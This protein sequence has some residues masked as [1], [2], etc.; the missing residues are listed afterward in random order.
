MSYKGV[1]RKRLKYVLTFGIDP[2]DIQ[3]FLKVSQK[4]LIQAGEKLQNLPKKRSDQI[5][6]ILRFGDKANLV[7]ERWLREH[8]PKQELIPAA[9]IVS[10]FREVEED[11]RQLSDEDQRS[12]SRSI[13]LHLLQP[14]VSDELLAFM[15]TPVRHDEGDAHTLSD[16]SS[17]GNTALRHSQGPDSPSDEDLSAISAAIISSGI[18]AR[19]AIHGD[20]D[21]QKFALALCFARELD[22]DSLA[23]IEATLPEGSMYRSAVDRIVSTLKAKTHRGVVSLPIRNMVSPREVKLDDIETIAICTNAAPQGTSVFFEPLYLLDKDGLIKCSDAT[24]SEIFPDTGQIMAFT[25]ALTRVPDVG[26]VGAWSVEHHDTDR[27]IK[28]HVRAAATPVFEVVNIDAIS[29]DYGAVRAQLQSVKVAGLGRAVFQTIDKLLFRPRRDLGDIVRDGIKEPFDAWLG[30]RG[31][32]TRGRTF[33]LVSLGEQAFAYDCAPIDAMIQRV[34]SLGSKLESSP[35]LTKAEVRSLADAIGQVNANIDPA[36][37]NDVRQHL[38]QYLQTTAGVDEVVKLIMMHPRVQRAIQEAKEDAALL[39]K[40]ARD[41]LKTDIKRLQEERAALEK[42]IE[43]KQAEQQQLPAKVARAVRKA[44]GKAKSD[45]VETLG[46]IAVL[47][48]LLHLDRALGQNTIG[49]TLTGGPEIVWAEV[50]CERVSVEDVLVRHGLSTPY[51]VAIDRTLRVA[52]KAGLIVL[53]TGVASDSVADEIA[54]A[55]TP[56]VAMSGTIAIGLLGAEHLRDQVQQLGTALD[57]LVLK[58]ANHSDI[59]SYGSELLDYVVKRVVDKDVELPLVILTVSTGPSALPISVRLRKLAI[60]IDLDANTITETTNASGNL[61]DIIEEEE[62]DSGH[63]IWP[64]L[65]KRLNGAFESSAGD[66]TAEVAELLR[67]GFIK[68]ALQI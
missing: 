42:A 8:L 30:L 41:D 21:L 23:E 52:S 13:V 46:T 45:G 28:V 17:D 61:R 57:G 65:R 54:R 29:D 56:K 7:L 24:Y 67:T 60:Q 26:S 39:A 64:P 50:K 40:S 25:N 15:K 32:E 10:I 53:F 9:D 2:K 43:Q 14:D 18:E 62:R 51:A 34:V 36:R 44:F 16:S 35:K 49:L 6:A 11:K 20:S 5:T 66:Q 48:H 22:W 37:L 38:D 47:E 4:R 27:P 68:P 33:V 55:M 59:D 63:I 19:L 1:D 3:Q 12:L 31:F 58:M